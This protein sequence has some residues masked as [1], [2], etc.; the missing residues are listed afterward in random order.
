MARTKNRIGF[1][2]L[3]GLAALSLAGCA[4]TGDLDAVQQ[5]VDALDSQHT[6]IEGRLGALEQSL[7]SVESSAAEANAT[8]AKAVERAVKPCQ[9]TLSDPPA[10]KQYNFDGVILRY[11]PGAPPTAGGA[12][13]PRS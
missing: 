1:A 9:Y 11:T 13:R 3:A 8:A 7:A 5:R 2:T 6:A 12:S 4:S 10:G